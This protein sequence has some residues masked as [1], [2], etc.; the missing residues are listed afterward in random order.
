MIL[1][2]VWES[3]AMKMRKKLNIWYHLLVRGGAWSEADTPT[4]LQTVCIVFTLILVNSRGDDTEIDWSY[5]ILHIWCRMHWVCLCVLMKAYM[6]VFFPWWCLMFHCQRVRQPIMT[7]KTTWIFS[8]NY[9]SP[10]DG[11]QDSLAD[12]DPW[13]LTIGPLQRAITW[14]LYADDSVKHWT[15]TEH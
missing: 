3:G 11:P 8:V 10:P 4:H 7:S 13:Q 12:C 6:E 9:R 2:K 1:L 14:C 15:Q 5:N